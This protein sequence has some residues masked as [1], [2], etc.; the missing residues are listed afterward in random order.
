MDS[1]AAAMNEWLKPGDQITEAAG[2]AVKSRLDIMLACMEKPVSL[3]MTVD[4]NGK[5]LSG[6]YYPN[7][8]DAD[9]PL[10]LGFEAQVF[11][12]PS[13]TLAQAAV[14]GFENIGQTVY[15][16]GTFFSLIGRI[17]VGKSVSGPVRTT[18]YIGQ[19]AV[20]GF[21][22]SFD[23]G[24][25]QFILILC[26]LSVIL[27]VM[28]LLPFGIMDGGFIVLYVIEMIRRKPYRP[29]FLYRFQI[30]GFVV[31]VLLGI[32]VVANDFMQRW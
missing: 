14:K 2:K 15:S 21:K 32:F 22:H 8:G 7:Y 4:R 10:G 25:V 13:Y 11:R 3:T 12:T 18:Y 16:I 1:L 23:Q 24:L 31:M 27:A 19:A 17:D 30:V 28:N 29:R 5:S 26:Y 9:M 6:M 20:E